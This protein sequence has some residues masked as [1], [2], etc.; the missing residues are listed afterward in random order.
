MP[1]TSEK[2]KQAA[3]PADRLATNPGRTTRAPI[4]IDEN[5]GPNGVEGEAVATATAMATLEQNPNP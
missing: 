1:A 2:R 3:N 4:P 5:P